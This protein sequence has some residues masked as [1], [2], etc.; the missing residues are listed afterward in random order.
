MK[1][2]FHA[3]FTFASKKAYSYL[4][5]SVRLFAPAS[6][7]QVGRGSISGTVTDWSGAMVPGS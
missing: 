3:Q 5:V 6:F 4:F 1:S 2:G 7:G